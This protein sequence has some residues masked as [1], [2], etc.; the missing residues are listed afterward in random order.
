MLSSGTSR[1]TNYRFVEGS[2]VE[3]LV[4]LEDKHWWYAERRLMVAQL[5]RQAFS[6]RPVS[7]VALD[8]GAAGGGNTRQ[9]RRAGFLAVPV[10]YGVE[11]AR[12][13]RDRGLPSVRG[14]ACQLPFGTQ[15]VDV[16][17]AFD[18]LEHIDDDSQALSEFARVL[19]PGAWLWV[20]VPCDMRLW[21][22]HDEA[23]GHVRRYSR[24]S[25]VDVLLAA[26]FD[27][28]DI[29]SWNV[30]L[31]PVVDFRRHRSTGSDLGDIG[32]VANWIL[33][34]IIALERFL[35]FLWDRDGVSLIVRARARGVAINSH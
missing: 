23:V 22:A 29:R 9:L 30:L 28:V 14:D 24:K 5:I 33:A 25:L 7:A 11:G 2:E 20:A 34:R 18:V 21:S 26:G 8:V 13:A 17:L 10:E 32:Q 12:V 1:M 35:P 15:S 19:R 6:D 3:K 27:V 4:A 31:R 16:V